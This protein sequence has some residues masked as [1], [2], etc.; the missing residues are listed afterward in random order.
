M[1]KTLT[2]G[3]NR[4]LKYHQKSDFHPNL[5]GHSASENTHHLVYADYLQE[6]GEEEL[7]H[8]VRNQVQWGPQG[9]RMGGDRTSD[10]DFVLGLTATRHPSPTVR[11]LANS[12]QGLRHHPDLVPLLFSSPLATDHDLAVALAH[13]DPDPEHDP[14]RDGSAHWV[15]RQINSRSGDYHFG[16]GLSAKVVNNTLYLLD[17]EQ[18]PFLGAPQIVYHADGNDPSDLRALWRH[19]D[20]LANERLQELR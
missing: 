15:A 14:D 20:H 10:Q 17:H 4:V 16:A 5:V 8:R 11:A 7:A 13:P 19:A 6:N 18:V 12:H 9:R 3:L 1:T 2:R